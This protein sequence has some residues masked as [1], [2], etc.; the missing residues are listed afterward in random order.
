MAKEPLEVLSEDA[1]REHATN[2][3]S[4]PFNTS[5]MVGMRRLNQFSGMFRSFS[6]VVVVVVLGWNC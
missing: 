2:S 3:S 6:G 1:G 4:E 5:L